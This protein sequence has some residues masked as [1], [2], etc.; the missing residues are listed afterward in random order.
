M[1]AIMGQRRTQVF[2]VIILYHVLR[3]QGLSL[4]K[5]QP[6]NS[7]DLLSSSTTPS[8]GV[9]GIPIHA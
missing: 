4:N 5:E 9:M 7:S 3:R 6:V 2:S 1:H 8:V